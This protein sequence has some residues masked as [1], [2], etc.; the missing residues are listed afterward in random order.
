M[1]RERTTQARVDPCL[2]RSV[3]FKPWAN[4]I[5]IVFLVTYGWA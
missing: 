4:V 2:F 1:K 5:K 3:F